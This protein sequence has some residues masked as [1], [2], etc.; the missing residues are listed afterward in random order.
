MA[1]LVIL[2]F[3]R[4]HAVKLFHMT[5]FITRFR[6]FFFGLCCVFLMT[7]VVRSAEL[8]VAVTPA[9]VPFSYLNERGELTGFNVEFGRAVCLKMKVSCHF[10]AMT[11]LR[12][13]STVSAGQADIG[14]SNA[15]KTP[16]RE[17]QVA[18]SVPY[19]RSTSSFFGVSGTVF[20]DPVDA[21]SKFKVCVINGS[22]QHEYLSRLGIHPGNVV[23]TL[24]N[25]NAI[26]SVRQGLCPLAMAP[27]MQ[28]LN[29]L[30]SPEGKGF[31]F[32]GAPLTDQGLGGTVHLVVR[33]DKPELLQRVDQAIKELILDGTHEKLSRRYFPFS[34][35]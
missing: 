12:I 6:L 33:P 15:L 10:E 7:P 2:C 5:R 22:R 13:L 27:T 35:L 19:W 30:Q 21:L 25:Q 3:L 20:K 8:V 16:E 1:A 34:I 29:F 11:F 17:K 23:A 14:L 28:I 31:S 26:D 18:F 24:S 32:L 4:M 9:V